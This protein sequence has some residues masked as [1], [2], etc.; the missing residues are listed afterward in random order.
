MD[1]VLRSNLKLRHLELLVALDEFR[2][3]GRASEFFS[4]TQSAV[5]KMLAEIERIF[6]VSLFVRST[7][8]TEPTAYGHTVVRFARSVLSNYDRTREEIAAVSSGAS[9]RTRVGAMPVATPGLLIPAI[10]LL[11]AQSSQTSIYV[12][13]GDLSRLLPRLRQTE[14]DLIVGHL[15]PGYASP[16]LETETLYDE[17]MNVICETGHRLVARKKPDWSDLVAQPWVVPPAW[18]SWRAKLDQLFHERKLNPPSD[19][20]E[21]ASFLVML[22]VMRQRQALG[23]V[24]H[25]VA[26]HLEREKLARI[27]NV[28]VAIE[29]P[30]VGIITI[31]GSP[32][33]PATQQIIEALRQAA[34]M[35]P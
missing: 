4:L 3:L 28:K 12:E 25:S 22:T 20:V 26:M 13:E 5:S 11:K 19:L 8:G 35:R 33:T 23:I 10:D 9:S 14:L 30:P 29:L 32:H 15:E 21:T 17:P 7:R 1:R 16:D 34:A 18:A 24:G 31:R 2:N 6:D 27:I